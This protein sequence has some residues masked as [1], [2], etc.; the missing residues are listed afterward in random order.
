M[1]VW[2]L[3][4]L[5]HEGTEPFL[6]PSQNH[7][8]SVL[9]P[10]EGTA[11]PQIQLLASIHG[12]SLVAVGLSQVIHGIADVCV[13][14]GTEFSSVNRPLCAT[15]LVHDRKNSIENLRKIRSAVK[16]DL[17]DKSFLPKDKK[18]TLCK[19]FVSVSLLS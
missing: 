17:K 12:Q 15:R 2:G 4:G 14:D 19:I 18:S 16:E 7:L 3:A 8:Q 9:S 11:D 5:N 10:G 13:G 1:A 6:S